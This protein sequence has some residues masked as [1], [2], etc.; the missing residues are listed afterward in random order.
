VAKVSDLSNNL[1]FMTGFAVAVQQLHVPATC[2]VTAI[3]YKYSPLTYAMYFSDASNSTNLTKKYYKFVFRINETLNQFQVVNFQTSDQPIP[4]FPC[5]KNNSE[6]NTGYL[7][8]TTINEN[9]NMTN[10]TQSI[11][12]TT[13]KD[14]N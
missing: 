1:V 7:I 3:F 10:E 13:T 5:T 4:P 6:T 11:S 12:N 8:N 14:K 2:S 9:S